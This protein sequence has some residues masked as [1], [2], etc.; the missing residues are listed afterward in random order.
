MVW[1]MKWYVLQICC[2]DNHISCT[3]SGSENGGLHKPNALCTQRVAVSHLRRNF[4]IL[5]K[6]NW[7]EF[8]NVASQFYVSWFHERAQRK[9]S[10]TVSHHCGKFSNWLVDWRGGFQSG[11]V[12]SRVW[13]PPFSEKEI[14]NLDKSL[15]EPSRICSNQP[16]DSFTSRHSWTNAFPDGNGCKRVVD[17]PTIEPKITCCDF[18]QAS[19]NWGS[20]ICGGN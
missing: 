14:N 7:P 11:T 8:S 17:L 2:L 1:S 15:S 5:W 16:V 12:G 9:N 10:Q 18:L 3:T 6:K 4:Q 19:K 13:F 20:R